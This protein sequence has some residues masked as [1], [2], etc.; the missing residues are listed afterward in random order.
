MIFTHEGLPRSGKSYEAV[1]FHILPALKAGTQ[2]YVRLNGVWEQRAEIAKRLEMTVEQVEALLHPM[3][4]REVK[5]WLVCRTNNDGSMEFP[6]IPQNSLVV[7]DEAQEYWPTGRASMPAEVENF[8]S[9]HGH[10]NL[11]IVLQTQD[12]KDLHRHVMRRVAK[13][14]VYT[15]LDALGI[16]KRYSVR[17]FNRVSVDKFETMGTETRVY[18][19]TVFVCYH[20]VQPGVE[21]NAVYKS[22]TR[23][24]W[25]TAKWPAIAVAVSLLL[26][27][28]MLARFF[29]G[30]G[31]PEVAKEKPTEAHAP[32]DVYQRPVEPV[33]PTAVPNVAAVYQQPV[34]PVDTAPAAVRYVSDL[35]KAGRPRFA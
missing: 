6:H 35:A 21:E 25:K 29:M 11:N 34:E 3:G 14:N 7:V 31:A 5:E 8:F 19:E 9:K 4:D 20:G 17:F 27:V 23:T 15:K 13:R 10:A 18:D 28:G 26:G 24:L 1:L 30:G 12:W 2:T 33:Q 32:G 16:D 22:N